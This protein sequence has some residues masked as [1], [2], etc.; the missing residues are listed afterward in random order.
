[1]RDALDASIMCHDLHTTSMGRFVFR[2]IAAARPDP[3]ALPRQKQSWKRRTRMSAKRATPRRNRSAYGRRA[4]VSIHRLSPAFRHGENQAR[5]KFHRLR[6]HWRV[7]RGLAQSRNFVRRLTRL[8]NRLEKSGPEY[9][10]LACS[11]AKEGHKAAK[12]A[13]YDLKRERFRGPLQ[14]IPVRGEGSDRLRRSSHDVGSQALRRP[15]LRL[16][17]RGDRRSSWNRSGAHWKARHGGTCGR[18]RLPLSA[19]AVLT[20]PRTQ[21]VGPNALVGRIFQ[22]SARRGSG[23]ARAVRPRRRRPRAPS[24][25]P[26]VTAA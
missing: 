4:R 18:R 15:G 11:L 6:H 13:D 16:Q 17:R 1:M 23:R 20:R 9:N 10:A 19:A 8:S 22:R 3:V 2:H 7:E 25:R 24:S 5:R 12:D 21:S 26:P 14:G